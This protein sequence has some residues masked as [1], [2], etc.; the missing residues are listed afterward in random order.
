MCTA[1]EQALTETEQG[2]ELDRHLVEFARLLRELGIRVSASEI[3]DAMQGLVLVGMEDKDRVEAVLQATM[4]KDPNQIPWFKEAFRAYFATP[5][6][7]AAWQTAAEERMAGWQE[8][9]G[10]S[11]QELRFQGREMDIPEEQLAIY[12]QMPEEEQQRLR[13]FLARSSQGMKSGAPVDHSF[14]PVIERVVR[15]S[16]EYWRRRLGEDDVLL[17]PGSADGITSEVEQ[18]IRE[19]EIHLLAQ[20]LK[21]INPEDWPEVVKLIRRLSQRLANQISRRYR[22]ARRRGGVD[23]RRTLRANLR[24]GGVL[25]ERRFRSRHSGRPR[26]VL[27]CDLS[28]SM[29]KYTEFVLQ[30]VYGLSSVVSGIET[31]AFADRLVHLTPNIHKGQSFP[32]MVENAL[33]ATSKQWGGGTNLANSLETM[34]QEFPNV[35]SKR[36]VLI[37][38]SDTQTLEGERA[39]SQLKDIRRRVREILWLNTLPAHRWA[40]AQ[41]VDLFKPL[42]QMYE[43]YTLGHLTNILSE[44]L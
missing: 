30:F 15:G 10:R 2:S 21:K 14:Q 5:E 37:I 26:F 19:K 44:R 11:R 1:N 22:A 38:L 34:R 6:Q 33:P 43:C 13:D 29:L 28:G 20:D 7:K 23:M 39:A 8:K 36:T 41:T 17:P 16:L 32:E 12:A 42:C 3:I 18:A 24:Y 4:V 40:E 25:V 9:L 31:F 27:L 35:F